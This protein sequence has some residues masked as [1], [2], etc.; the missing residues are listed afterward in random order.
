[1]KDTKPIRRD[2]WGWGCQGGQT[3]FFKHDHMA[4]QIDGDDEQNRMQVKFLPKG[5]TGDLGVRSKGQIYL[6]SV[7]MSI[8]MI[9]IPNFVCVL[10]KR[11]KKHIEQ[12]F[13]SIAGGHAKWMELGVAGG[14]NFSVAIC[15]GAPSTARSSCLLFSF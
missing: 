5:Q 15:D 13:H 2:F 8:S 14:Q 12:N 4:Y 9:F 3:F 11:D 10:T 7:A 6:I 1:M